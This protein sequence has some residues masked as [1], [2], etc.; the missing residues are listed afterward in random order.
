MT[1]G[2]MFEEIAEILD[3]AFYNQIEQTSPIIDFEFDPSR[4]L[5]N[6][7]G[8]CFISISKERWNQFHRKELPWVDGNESILK[9][10]TN[11]NLIITEHP[12]Q[13]LEQSVT[14]II[15]KDS[16][17]AIKKLAQAARDKMESPVIGIT[18]SVGKSS[19]RLIL[20]HLLKDMNTIVATRGNHNTQVGVPLYGTKLCQNPKIGILE[21]SLN[22]LNNRGNQSL[23]V[24]PNVCVVTSI[25]EAHLS[26]LH[27]TI[28]VAKF[29]ARIF[30]G[31]EENGL[32]IINKDMSP[33]EFNILYKRAK[34]RTN[35]IKTYSLV[36][37]SADL[38]LKKRIHEKYKTTIV[39]QY[40]NKD[41]E[42]DMKLPS[43]GTIMNTL[44]TFLCLAE[45]DYDIQPLLSKMYDFK[46]LD[47]VMELKQ[48][49][50]K[51]RRRIDI[52][53]DSHN[54]AIPSMINAI[55]TFTE[56]QKF[57]KGTKLL[58][59]GQVADLGDQSEA[60]HDLL[61]PYILDSGAD[62]VF[63]HGHY[64]RKVIRQLPAD[65]VGG[66]F[67]NAQDLSKRVPYY[68][69]DDSF[70]VLKGSVSGSDFRK[71]SH[72]LPAN[73]IRST[74]E[75]RQ[76]TP[77]LLAEVMQP[78]WGMVGYDLS[79]GKQLFRLG[80]INTQAIE[81]ISPILFLYLLFK[82]GIRYEETCYLNQWPTNKGMSIAN[83]PFNKG[84]LF[85][86]RELVDELIETQHPSAIFELAYLYFGSRHKAMHEIMDLA[87]SF[88]ITSSA[89]LN[90]SGRY[91]VKEQQSFKLVDLLKSG[92]KM[93]QYQSQLPICL[94][95]NGINIRGLMF[96]RLQTH[97]IFFQNH[98]LI[99]V[100]GLAGKQAIIHKLVE[101]FNR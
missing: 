83:K 90:L 82:K 88:E 73:I 45:L 24:K 60:L 98:I 75:I 62:Y 64:M 29:K 25:G 71:T 92:Q 74:K 11:C 14:Q 96:G 78:Q 18:G 63:G 68:C 3:G 28:N 94:K 40:K 97:G 42:F 8:N 56:K 19:T 50:T 1:I 69:S 87:E 6:K 33:D 7:S 59:L 100:S 44:G 17:A 81:G 34:K 80:Y 5:E 31:L 15:V 89:T 49:Q 32:A 16:L 84:Q 52:I 101:I 12:I 22:A 53:D 55:Q 41:Y 72:L 43:D 39:F 67:N 35:R 93:S 27:S 2:F 79:R 70:I 37:N 13:Q 4:L 86:H 77:L 38:F 91:R 48:L 23:T 21:I 95:T 58:V 10:Y 30:D 54:A 26:T 99:C 9:Y 57:Y 20:E 36:D 61:I 46:S 51:D 47:R 85:T 66:W 76:P 65:M